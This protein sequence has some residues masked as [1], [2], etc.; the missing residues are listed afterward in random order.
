[1]KLPLLRKADVR[2]KT[3]FLRADLLPAVQTAKDE[4]KEIIYVG[5]KNF[6]S[7]ALS[8]NCSSYIILRKEDLN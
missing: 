3:V 8:R 5:F 2:G 4:G 6:I 1:M 7:Q